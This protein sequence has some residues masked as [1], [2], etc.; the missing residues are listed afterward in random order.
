MVELIMYSASRFNLLEETTKSLEKFLISRDRIRKIL[1]E[2]FVY[3]EKSE[4][5]LSNSTIVN[6]FDEIYYHNP[7]LGVGKSI[8]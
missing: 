1:H 5:V 6:F 7:P 4:I 8:E 2:D 3:P